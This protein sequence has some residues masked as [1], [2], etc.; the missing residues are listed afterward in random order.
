VSLRPEAPL[1]PNRC[2]FQHGGEERE[3]KK[4]SVLPMKGVFFGPQTKKKG[5]TGR[6]AK[7]LGGK[8]TATRYRSKNGQLRGTRQKKKR[9]E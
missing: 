8:P 7:V 3:E 4:E 6:C 2:A 5:G 1:G 9:S